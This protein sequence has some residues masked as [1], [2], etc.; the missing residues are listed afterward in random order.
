MCARARIFGFV[1][2]RASACVAA[3]R[4]DVLL[5]RGRGV[6]GSGAVISVREVARRPAKWQRTP[7][8][9]NPVSP[10]AQVVAIATRPPGWAIIHLRP[11]TGPYL[12]LPP[13]ACAPRALR[14]REK[15]FWCSPP[16][17]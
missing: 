15:I 14:L 7:S 16:T 6:S 3:R 8:P 4:F 13:Q 12:G 5:P 11:G 17:A 2:R 1:W 10:R 9:T